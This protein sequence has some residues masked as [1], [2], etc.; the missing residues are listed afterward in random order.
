MSIPGLELVVIIAG[1]ACF[2]R[3]ALLAMGGPRACEVAEAAEAGESA[4]SQGQKVGDRQFQPTTASGEHTANGPV[5]TLCAGPATP[6]F[7]PILVMLNKGFE[8]T[9][10]GAS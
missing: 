7:L 1:R 9:L 4:A 3:Q 6:L 10:L 8:N 5:G 2:E